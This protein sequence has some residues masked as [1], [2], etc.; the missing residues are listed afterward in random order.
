MMQG[1]LTLPQE[2]QEQIIQQLVSGFHIRACSVL[3][4]R[5]E[6]INTV[7][8]RQL[9]WKVL[10]QHD[11]L[12]AKLACKRMLKLCEIVESRYLLSP[13]MAQFGGSCILPNSDLLRAQDEETR[14][15]TY[16]NHPTIRGIPADLETLRTLLDRVRTFELPDD[17]SWQN[18]RQGF[19]MSSSATGPAGTAKLV[20]RF[21]SLENIVLGLGM[22]WFD[23]W[24]PMP[25]NFIDEYW[26]KSLSGRSAHGRVSETIKEWL[27]ERESPRLLIRFFVRHGHGSRDRSQH[28]LVCIASFKCFCCSVLEGHAPLA[29]LSL[30][31]GV[32]IVLISRCRSS[33]L[34][35]FDSKLHMTTIA[36]KF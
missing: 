27:P 23:N 22:T 6:S 19:W 29:H 32:Y 4:R 24:K 31:F 10:A 16:S 12:H 21:P 30:D 35:L 9:P 34:K 13:H 1:L 26:T 28:I 8:I 3:E 17:C 7:N 2:L 14:Y 25:C 36:C 20:E 33:S 15:T 5:L 11:I 18:R